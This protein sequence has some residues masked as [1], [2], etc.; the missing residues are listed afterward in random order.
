[1]YKL[2]DGG[3]EY[4]HLCSYSQTSDGATESE[5]KKHATKE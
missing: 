3:C 2:P 1:M 4:E 5:Q